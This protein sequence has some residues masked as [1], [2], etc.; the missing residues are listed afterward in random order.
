MK[1]ETLRALE[2]RDFLLRAE[3]VVSSLLR[4]GLQPLP[5]EEQ[6]E[7][8]LAEVLSV[9]WLG[10]EPRGAI[11]LVGDEAGTLE[12]RVNRGLSHEID[13][14]C[15]KVP[16]GRCL[17]GQAAL[18]G[19]VVFAPS[20]NEQHTVRY[21]GITPHGHYCVPILA[22]RRALGVLCLYVDDGHRRDPAEERFLVA[23]ADVMATVIRHQRTLAL[24]E[25][26]AVG[27]AQVETRSGRI[28]RVNERCCE[29]LGRAREELVGQTVSELT[30]D[31]QLE[32]E[33]LSRL[34]VG[35]SPE[36][37][38]ERQLRLGAEERWIRL[39]LSPLR[40]QGR[41]SSYL[42]AVV[43]DTSPQRRAERALRESEERFRSLFETMTEGVA[44]HE[45]IADEAGRPVDYRLLDV[46][47]AFTLHTGIRR[48][49]ALGRRASEV[50]GGAPPYLERY[51]G[52]VSTGTPLHF[53][54]Y[55]EPMRRHFRISA[56]SP[57]PRL[58]ATIFEDISDRKRMEL[59][60]QEK[61]AALR[62]QNEEL[63][64]FSHTVA[65][66]L[67]TPLS[68]V[69]GYANL[70]SSW[71][72]RLEARPRELAGACEAIERTGHRMA[73][74]IDELLLLAHARR[75]TVP[76]E[77]IDMRAV[78]EASLRAVAHLVSARAAEVALP[79]AW[80]VALGHPPWV[81]QIWTNY[82]GNAL[83]HGG[84]R[85]RLVLGATEEDGHARFWIQDDG[86]GLTPEQ[87][88][89]LFEPFSRIVPRTEGHGLG[90]SI[91]R[92]LAE[93]MGGAVGVAS[94][95]PGR[96]STFS[97][98]LPLAKGAEHRPGS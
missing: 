89:T 24:F 97:F 8:M 36:L 66:D 17:C 54:V 25:Q 2:E 41:S 34:R 16:L 91:V 76:I 21:P 14:S 35:G 68:V 4:I 32:G 19:E 5:L 15:A 44:L 9:P 6:L 7:Q 79:A 71:V 31:L 88:A 10:L 29:I 94:D 30:G 67:K 13:R 45:L 22:D 65:H 93:R 84:T 26:A 50:Y 70:L 75:A 58:F 46:N 87:Q 90:L 92:R 11:F 12:L 51:A 64:A 95:G 82:I 38:F 96:G 20:V 40:L 52:V 63:D 47:D 74:I 83:T 61:N 42:I 60:L 49:D 81:E 85:P 57:G 27:V 59:A 48:G 78:V 72:A 37:R 62:A 43:E 18:L 3:Q 56:F 73:R 80:P 86:E 53:E 69:T 33:S 28:V 1:G 23:V 98:S 39:T 55:F 77:P